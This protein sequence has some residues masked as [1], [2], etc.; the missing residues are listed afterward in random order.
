MVEE[1]R[2]LLDDLAIRAET[3][4]F[5]FR[6]GSLMKHLEATF[7]IWKGDRSWSIPLPLCPKCD[8]DLKAISRKAA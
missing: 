4:Q 7:F 1:I 6:C 2:S 8:V 5:C 3:N